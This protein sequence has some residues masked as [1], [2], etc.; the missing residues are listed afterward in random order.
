MTLNCKRLVNDTHLIWE[1]EHSSNP[2]IN[3]YHT[4]SVMG[5]VNLSHVVAINYAEKDEYQNTHSVF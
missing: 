4:N 1:R 5:I 3:H 2:I